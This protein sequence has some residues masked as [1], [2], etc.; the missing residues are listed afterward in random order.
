MDKI[1]EGLSSE[2]YRVLSR[3]AVPIAINAEIGEDACTEVVATVAFCGE[4]AR[5]NKSKVVFT[6]SF[7]KSACEI[8][9]AKNM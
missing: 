3:Q 6:Y 8:Q 1:S 5:G 7:L 2:T 4:R 9:Q